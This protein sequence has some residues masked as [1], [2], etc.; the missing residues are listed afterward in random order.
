MLHG[1]TDKPAAELVP[2]AKSWLYAPWM[3]LKSGAY[4]SRGYDQTQRAYLL[5]CKERGK[6]SKLE[7][8]LASSE[9]SP[10][11][12]PAFVIEDWGGA[13]VSLK[14]NGEKMNRG[15]DFRFGHRRTLESNDLIV[16][17]RTESTKPM[18][19]LLT[20]VPD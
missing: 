18:D 7:L 19:I 10:V 4:R 6:P 20:P 14:V 2:L 11:V 15:K 9:R 3:Q 12:N 1:M 5:A 8:K 16:W 17:F 13:G